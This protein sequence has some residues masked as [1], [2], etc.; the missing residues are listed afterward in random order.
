MAP[1]VGIGAEGPVQRGWGLWLTSVLGV[2]IATLF[3]GARLV[4][5]IIKRSGLGMDDYMI[6]A[7]LISSGLLS[8]TECQGTCGCV[9]FLV[10]A[11]IFLSCC[12]RLRPTLGY[13]QPRHSRN[14]TQVVLRCQHYVQGR[15]YV[16]QDLHC[17]SILPDFRR[18]QE[19]LPYR[20]PRNECLDCLLEPCLHHRNNF[21]M[22]AGCCILGQKHTGVQMF[23]ESTM[24]DILRSH[25]DYDRLRIDV[26]AHTADYDALYGS[27]REAWYL[28]GVCHCCFVS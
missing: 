20:L 25:A 4:Q 11:N 27:Y 23:P 15:P 13:T 2:V 22:H 19:L 16:Q 21:P 7:A 10:F 1:N 6:V 12:V 24:V 14:R 5:R 28:L 8:M 18:L 26:H 3:V 9:Q 17:M